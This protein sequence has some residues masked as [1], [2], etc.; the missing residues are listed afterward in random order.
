MTV[1]WKSPPAKG[2]PCDSVPHDPSLVGRAT[3]G[4][5]RDALNHADLHFDGAAHRVDDAAELDDRAID[6]R[7]TV[8]P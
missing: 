4:E 7:L 3:E 5:D 1:T 8:R 6:V 2:E